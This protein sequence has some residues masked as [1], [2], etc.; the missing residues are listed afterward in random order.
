[1]KRVLFLDHAPVLGGA[2]RSLLLILRGL[3]GRG[4]NP[5][6]ACPPGELADRAAA[7]GIPV[8][9]LEYPRL[10]RSAIFLSNLWQVSGTL[11]RT[12]RAGQVGAVY[13][14]TVRTAF[15]GMGAARRVRLPFLWHMRDFWLS[16]TRP[17]RQWSDVLG[18]RMLTGAARRVLANSHAVAALLPASPKIKVIHN[19][20]DLER[21]DPAMQGAPFRRLAGFP[22]D[23]AVA[24]MVARLR[25]WKGQR[26]FL[27]TMD[28]VAAAA[29][30][31]RFLVVG[32][33]LAG[34]ADG[35][36]QELRAA[37]AGLGLADK[38]YFSGQLDDVRPALAAMD[39]FVHCG[40]PE[41][42]GLVNL[43]AMAMGK[44][45]VA[46]HQGAL[47]EIV[48]HRRTGL[49]V[50]AGD[51]GAL[52]QAVLELLTD[53]ARRLEMGKAGRQRVGDDFAL[54]RMIERIERVLREVSD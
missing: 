36:E 16:E 41:P 42:F 40:D 10:R 23:A 19:A 5:L 35:Y 25:P 17:S 22:L 4:W 14:N 3:L 11:A 45:V 26:T 33:S 30:R 31:S 54:E 8:H 43:E 24:G 34:A 32:G 51:Q 6:L 18:K 2:E 29:P 48:V 9:P 1:M 46:F 39:V 20:I 13:A 37:A 38:V 12:A 15:Y 7:C 50:P 47:P 27:E 52:A 28:R 49:L 53:R 44:P 21:F